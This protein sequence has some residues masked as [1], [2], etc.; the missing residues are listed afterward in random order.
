MN[1][2][3]DR[4]ATDAALASEALPDQSEIQAEMALQDS[5]DRTANWDRKD[6]PPLPP[7]TS[8]ERCPISARATRHPD[9]TAPQETLDHQ[10]SQERPATQEP[11]D[12][13][14]PQETAGQPDPR[15]GQDLREEVAQ[16]ADQE[17]SA[18]DQTDPRD[19]QA[20]QAET[21]TQADRDL[22][23]TQETQEAKDP[24]GTPASP[25]TQDS[26]ETPET[27][28]WRDREENRDRGDRA[29]TA[30]RPVWLRV[31]SKRARS[32][33]RRQTGDIFCNVTHLS[34]SSFSATTTSFQQQS[35]VSSVLFISTFRQ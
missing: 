20:S 3:P 6:L 34:N 35:V 27:Q 18:Q 9:P 5:R 13:P 2:L 28:V 17:S 7:R 23:A 15:A 1:E 4:S 29:T 22:P 32:G 14:V 11:T 30:H 24:Q 25:A 8:W 26:Q 10:D 16:T 33:I 31:T 12:S 21:E 19:P